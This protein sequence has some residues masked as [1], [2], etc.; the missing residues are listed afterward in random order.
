MH[1]RPAESSGPA[2]AGA[3]APRVRRADLLRAIGWL[4]LTSLGGWPSYYHDSFVEQRKWLS[5]HEY[6][7]GAAISNLVPGPSFTNFTIFAA[8]RLGGWPAVPI[9]LL[10]V[11]LPG[12]VAMLLLSAWYAA[13]LAATPALTFALRGLGAAAAGLVVVTVLR[14]L[15]SGAVGRTGLLIGGIAFVALG[16]LGLS[17]FVV[18]PPL[19]V[20]AIW[21][22]RPRPAT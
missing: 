10:L 11:L 8:H 20:V 19:A 14:L 2:P 7:E 15:R 16:P 9:G 6:L 22:E 18:V 17:L 12:S 21:L 13:G 5:H 4:G 1:P 3:K